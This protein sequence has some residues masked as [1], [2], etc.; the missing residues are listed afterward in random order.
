[1]PAEMLGRVSS[2]DWLF[3]ICLSP[4]GIL[5][6]GVLATSIGARETMVAGALVSLA[7][8]VVA[9]VPGVRGPD[10]PDFQSIPLDSPEIAGGE[11]AS[12]S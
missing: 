9:F 11:A 4:L 6:A 8:A 10:R 12:I 7:T 5:V 2:V 1:M 3:S